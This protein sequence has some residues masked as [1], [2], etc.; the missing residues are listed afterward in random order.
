[1]NVVCLDRLYRGGSLSGCCT[2]RQSARL[3]LTSLSNFQLPSLQRYS[4]KRIHDVLLA[5]CT[6]PI[7]LLP[8]SAVAISVCLKSTW[9]C[10]RPA[11]DWKSLCDRHKESKDVGGLRGHRGHWISKVDSVHR[12]RWLML[13]TGPEDICVLLPGLKTRLHLSPS[14]ASHK[15]S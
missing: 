9:M 11:F 14:G 15:F 3:I 12:T 5:S 7:K 4:I 1:M 10:V 8:P 13:N 6:P 2:V